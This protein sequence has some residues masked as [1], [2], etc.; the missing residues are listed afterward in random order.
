VI[1]ISVGVGI[2]CFAFGIIV[3]RWYQRLYEEVELS[4][5]WNGY[6]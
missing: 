5:W 3:G 6:R 4:N 2:V 1:W